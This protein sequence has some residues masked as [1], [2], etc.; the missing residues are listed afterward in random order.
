MEIHVLIKVKSFFLRLLKDLFF[1][2]EIQDDSSSINQ[3]VGFSLASI[4]A[5]ISNTS[6]YTTESSA[7]TT[8]NVTSHRMDSTTSSTTDQGRL[9]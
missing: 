2:L 8:S 6:S 4:N 7:Q 9:T 5:N 3:H 1:A